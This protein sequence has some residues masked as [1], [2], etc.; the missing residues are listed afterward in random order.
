MGAISFI[1]SLLKFAFYLALAGGIAYGVYW[2]QQTGAFLKAL[3]WL[4]GQD[5]L[6]LV[7]I[8]V[9]GLMGIAIIAS[10]VT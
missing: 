10:V 7:I 8:S 1:K 9:V 3:E 6:L 5:P 2:G 4:S